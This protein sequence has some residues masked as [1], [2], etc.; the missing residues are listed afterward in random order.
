VAVVQQGHNRQVHTLHEVTTHSIQT[1]YTKHNN[2]GHP[3]TMN[4]KQIRITTTEN[5]KIQ[6][7]QQLTQN[8][9]NT[10]R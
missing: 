10:R 5:K 2:K 3:T 6:Q 9:N 7:I 8:T 4:T 1:Q